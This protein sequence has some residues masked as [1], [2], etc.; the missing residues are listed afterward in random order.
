MWKTIP[1]VANFLQISER[2]VWRKIKA[3]DLQYKKGSF[4]HGVRILILISNSEQNEQDEPQIIQS[5]SD[6]TDKSERSD[7]CDSSDRSDKANSNKQR[8]AR[9]KSQCF[10]ISKKSTTEI[11]DLTIVEINR[12]V[13][14][15]SQSTLPTQTN[16][17][18]LAVIESPT[19]SEPSHPDWDKAR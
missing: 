13:K 19:H 3:G 2:S 8:K 9:S 17:S 10:D 15:L 6:R 7:R 16:P 18:N 11:T 5:S 1:E 4:E 12:E 14:E